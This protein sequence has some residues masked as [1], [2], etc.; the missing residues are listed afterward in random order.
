VDDTKALLLNSKGDFAVLWY[1]SMN[2]V[3]DKTH[4][5]TEEWLSRYKDQNQIEY[6]QSEMR[7]QCAAWYSRFWNYGD[8]ALN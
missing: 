1:W 5:A 4:R 7:Q 2:S 6:M 8:S 3:E